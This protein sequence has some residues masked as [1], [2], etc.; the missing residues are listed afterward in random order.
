MQ[1]Q[2][3]Q[4]VQRFDVAPEGDCAVPT[5]GGSSSSSGGSGQGATGGVSSS[6]R[7]SGSMTRGSAPTLSA[8]EQSSHSST[9]SEYYDTDSDDDLYADMDDAAVAARQFDDT[10]RDIAHFFKHHP[11]LGQAQALLR[12]SGVHKIAQ[13][14]ALDV[15]VMVQRGVCERDAEVILAA[16]HSENPTGVCVCLLCCNSSPRPIM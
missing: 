6:A 16:L 1:P 10:H 14:K 2:R 4:A 3:Q 11:S 8:G 9:Y 5:G 13:L 7:S 12:A 15:P